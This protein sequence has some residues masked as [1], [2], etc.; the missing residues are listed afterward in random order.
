MVI[1]N[2][3]IFLLK[4]TGDFNFGAEDI[5]DD[6]YATVQKPRAS[7]VKES[8]DIPVI[9]RNYN[10]VKDLPEKPPERTNARSSQH[11][12]MGIINPEEMVEIDLEEGEK[13]KYPFYNK[14]LDLFSRRLTGY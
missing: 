9:V 3:P 13:C 4:A 7:V 2:N 11:S 10:S 14:Y 8:S 12:H 6:E 5:I 1:N